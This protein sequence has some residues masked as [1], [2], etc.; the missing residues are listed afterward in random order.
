M[1]EFQQ[2]KVWLAGLLGLS[3]D[4]LH[5]SVGLLVFLVA[6]ALLRARLRDWKPLLAVVA[7]AA[8]GEA[9]DLVDTWNAGQRLRWDRSWHDLW[10]TSLWPAILFLLARWTKLLRP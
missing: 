7:A 1:S 2:T 3:K 10:V 4:A 8:I 5:I 9:W 6:L